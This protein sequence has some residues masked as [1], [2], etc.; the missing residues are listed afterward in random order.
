MISDRRARNNYVAGNPPGAERRTAAISSEVA[1]TTHFT[2]VDSEGNI[3]NMTSTVEGPFG[4]QL[5]ARG[6]VLNNELTDFTFAPEKD[7]APVANRVEAGKRPLSSMSPT[8]VYNSQ[9]EPVLALGSAGGKRIIM[10]VTKTLIGVLD[11]DLTL[12]Q[13]MALPNIYFRRDKVLIEGASDLT[14]LQ[15]DIAKYG[16]VVDTSGLPS[17]LA[18]AQKTARGWV[19]AVDPRS[20][21]QAVSELP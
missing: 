10:H 3:A 9:N 7:G 6:M 20:T 11:Y 2:A 5:L 16:H 13:A 8:I 12:E 19:G 4:S 1:G 21:G 14:K 18:G 17:K 15:A